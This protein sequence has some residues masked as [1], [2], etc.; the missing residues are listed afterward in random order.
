MSLNFESVC[1]RHER[2]VYEE[3]MAQSAHRP[4]LRHDL[5]LLADAAC[6]A[7]NALRPHYIRHSVDLA[8]YMSEAQLAAETA[9]IK[10]AVQRALDHVQKN[11]HPA[12]D[13]RA[14]GR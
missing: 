14:G 4:E 12:K 5:Q 7:L 9:E 8:F 6:V 11:A 13:L 2:T 3:I 10:A 1:N